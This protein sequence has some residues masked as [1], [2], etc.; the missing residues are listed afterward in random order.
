MIAIP[1]R[2]L[3]HL[4]LQPLLL[5]TSVADSLLHMFGILGTSTALSRIFIV[6]R[7]A[8]SSQMFNLVAAGVNLYDVFAHSVNFDGLSR[9]KQIPARNF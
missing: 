9:W 3:Y 6:G 5:L 1:S 7:L 8:W 4:S 2:I